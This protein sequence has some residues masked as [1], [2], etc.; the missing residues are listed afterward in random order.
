[1]KKYFLLILLFVLCSLQLKAQFNK[2]FEFKYTKAVNYTNQDKYD[3]ALP[4][5]LKLDSMVPNN[6]NLNFYIG[7]CYVSMPKEKIKA[8]SYLEKAIVNIS[9]DYVGDYNETTAP[10]Y[11]LL[12]LSKAYHLAERLDDEMIALSNFKY[13]LTPDQVPMINEVD[14]Q[15]ESCYNAKKFM[16]NPLKITV[17]N[18]GTNI[19]TQYPEYSPVI[20]AKGDTLIFTSRREG[21]TGGLK[22]EYGQYFEDIYFSAYDKE[23]K[24]WKPAEKIGDSINT[25]GHEASISLSTDGGQLFIYKDDYGD[26]NIYVSRKIKGVWGT[27]EKLGPE[28]NGSKTRETHACLS[29]DGQT[30]YFVSDRPG[31][32]G[33]TDIWM[34][35]KLSNGKW[36]KARNLGPLINTPLDE[37]SPFIS[38]DGVTLYFS[39][40]GHENMG[41]FDIFTVTLSE[42]GQWTNLEN[43]GYP[44]NTTD[45]DVF[46]VPTADEKHAY[47]SSSKF[48]GF[49]DQD[50]YRI[51]ILASK[52]HI[53]TIKGVVLDSLSGN[54]VEAKVEIKDLE[55][56]E[57]ISSF[58]TSS[59]TGEYYVTLPSGKE[60][61]L[62]FKSEAYLKHIETIDIPESNQNQEFD[63]KIIL[64]R[65][66]ESKGTKFNFDNKDFIGGERVILKG[67]VFEPQTSAI[68]PE[69]NAE[70]G[71]LVDF[72]K[73]NP[74][75]KILI[76]AHTDNFGV[77]KKCMQVTEDRATVVSDYL[78]SQGVDKT[79]LTM[80]G[81]GYNHPIS[82]SK[83]EEGKKKNNRIEF[84]LVSW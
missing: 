32:Y 19:N 57:I 35:E 63:K 54:P 80:E 22:D 61:E 41:G 48:G 20:N 50:I 23:N 36:G 2:D 60:Y 69:S 83:T 7:F 42:D 56:Y 44:I 79:R 45:D 1:M 10:I 72:M 11:A 65:T 66:A 71:K 51:T 15:T 30:L 43:M 9:L 74:N 53:A 49:G 17:E 73:A 38:A 39:S 8:I 3:E 68:K 4:I 58:T 33:G 5:F 82:D 76:T 14:L 84:K 34:S 37:E 25:E 24:A 6:A 52:K 28:I 26:G 31:G 40:Q 70:L 12:Y 81:D 46:Y 27:P 64:V 55:T 78:I 67:V 75:V 59:K 13:Y 16:S 62:I 18:L 29:P 77:V 47:Y 21:S